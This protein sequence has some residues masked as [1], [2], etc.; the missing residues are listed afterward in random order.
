MLDCAADGAA[1]TIP[2]LLYSTC[3]TPAGF[4]SYRHSEVVSMSDVACTTRDTYTSC[5]LVQRV[6][7]V[8]PAKQR[9]RRAQASSCLQLALRALLARHTRAGRPGAPPW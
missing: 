5:V 7:R 8:G 6:G 4:V 9:V 2:P 1:Q 3:H